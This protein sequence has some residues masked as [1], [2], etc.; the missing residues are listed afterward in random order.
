MDSSNQNIHDGVAR[1]R[2]QLETCH[3]V[4][5]DA[6]MRE[7]N[8][9]ADGGMSWGRGEWHV[10]PRELRSQTFCRW[11]SSRCFGRRAE[12]SAP[13]LQLEG[14]R[15]LRQSFLTGLTH[16]EWSSLQLST[17]GLMLEKN[18]GQQ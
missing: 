13:Q 6:A 1:S 12:N 18:H 14:W 11:P 8:K 4:P 2:S 10:V 7:P 17:C 5:A 9:I 15:G 3:V 16:M